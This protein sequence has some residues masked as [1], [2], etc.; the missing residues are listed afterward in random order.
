MQVTVIVSL[1]FGLIKKNDTRVDLPEAKKV[2]ET[3]TT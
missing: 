1:Y 3:Q 2:K